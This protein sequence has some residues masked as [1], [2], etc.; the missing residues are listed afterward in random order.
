[1]SVFTSVSTNQ[2]SAWLHNYSLGDLIDLRGISS[3]IENTNYFVFTTKGKYVLTLFEKLQAEELP[4]YLNL[5]AHL[6]SNDISCP[7]PIPTLDNKLLGE[8]NNK[9]ASIVTCLPG[10][11]LTHPTANKCAKLG[12]TLARMHLS[13]LSYPDK[14]DNPRGLKWQQSNVPEILPFISAEEQKLLQQE[15]QFQALF[16]T[17]VL[18]HGIIHAD[19][20]L[21]NVLFDGDEIGGIIDFYFACHDSLLYDL[22]I[23]VNDWCIT[24]DKM[25]E[26]ARVG[27]LLQA[28]HQVRPLTAV[29]HQAWPTMLRAGALR[30]W[31]SRLIDY[32]IPRPGELTYA[33]DPVHFREI[34]RNHVTNQYELMRLWV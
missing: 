5:M 29:E 33:K 8:L 34:L 13:G 18:P 10:V 2:L 26:T 24:E 25:L 1:M 30:F 12:E 23:V 4:F 14:I 19:L 28:Y 22:A 21:D 31:L 16:Q 15:L 20:F 17:D 11:S 3:G 9:P 6:S 27:A 32:H 7:K